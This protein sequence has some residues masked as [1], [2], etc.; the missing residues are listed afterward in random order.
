MPSVEFGINLRF[1]NDTPLYGVGCGKASES[2]SRGVGLRTNLLY[3]AASIPNIG[4]EVPIKRNFSLVGEY[5]IP[6]FKNRNAGYAYQIMNGLLEARYYF[7]RS[8]NYEG[9]YAGAVGTIGCFDLLQ[10]ESGIQ[11][12]FYYTAG[13]T[14][15]YYKSISRCLGIDFSLSGG[16]FRGDLKHYTPDS[17]FD[18][19]VY[20]YTQAFEYI[21]PINA[22]VSV[23]WSPSFKSRRSR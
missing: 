6:W 18:C 7:S 16:I 14:V 15:G 10:N 22:R 21:G 20:Q 8:L 5:A 3:W 2:S 23:V 1:A 13:V 9:I 19:L 12:A 17:E 11:N 4:V